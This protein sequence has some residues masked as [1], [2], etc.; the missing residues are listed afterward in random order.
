MVSQ[1]TL[2]SQHCSWS[3]GRVC[4]T[5]VNRSY[6]PCCHDFIHQLTVGQSRTGSEE[7]EQLVHQLLVWKQPRHGW[8]TD[9]DTLSGTSAD[10]WIP[11]SLFNVASLYCLYSR[12]MLILKSFG[13]C[14]L[15]LR[16]QLWQIWQLLNLCASLSTNVRRSSNANKLFSSDLHLCNLQPTKQAWQSIKSGG[17]AFCDFCRL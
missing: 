12:G 10:L 8:R 2:V 16:V 15:G 5:L 7:A 17:G 11:W 1:E 6:K 9:G 14:S 4:G 13:T 3:D